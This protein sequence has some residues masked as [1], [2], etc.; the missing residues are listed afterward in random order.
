M[1]SILRLGAVAAVLLLSASPAFAW[2][3]YGHQTTAR[4]AWAEIQP[5]TRARITALIRQAARLDTPTCPIHDL[6]DAATWPD[7]IRSLGDRFKATYPWHYQDIDVC[8]AFDGH[9][10]CPDGNC[11]TAQI[12]R[13]GRRLGD[14][15][16]PVKERIEALAF[17]VHFTGDLHMPLHVGEHDDHGGNAIPADYG[18]I[19]YPR[20]SLHWVWDSYLAER[21]I[22]APPG[23]ARVLD[24]AITPAERREWRRGSVIDWAH[25]GW[26]ISRTVTYPLAVGSACG[27]RPAGRVQVGEKDVAATTPIIRRQIQRAG[28]RI[29]LLLDRALGRS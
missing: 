20:L 27:P 7:C 13:M 26:E 18:A 25:E 29:A 19:S 8:Q 5:V 16:L 11:I 24:R 15:R 12:E 10:N 17:L 23:G 2:G 1:K 21:A 3:D 14:R 28:I 22:S 6:A 4:I 9:A